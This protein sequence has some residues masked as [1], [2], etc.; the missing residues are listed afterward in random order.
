VYD[1]LDY[2]TGDDLF[3][4]QLPRAAEEC[5]PA[6]REQHP[7][8]VDI[9]VPERFSGKEHVDRWLGDLVLKHGE[10]RVVTP[11]R[12]EEHAV[13]NPIEEM[14]RMGLGEKAIVLEVPQNPEPEMG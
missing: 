7:D 2:M 8:L 11:L 1:I 6:L 9:D 10:T 12:P 14:V 3:T 13:I 4:H 5:A